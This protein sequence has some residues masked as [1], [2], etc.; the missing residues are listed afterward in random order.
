MS[1]S[2][3]RKNFGKIW[4]SHVAS[5]V[6]LL[7]AGRRAAGDMD[8]LLV[9]SVI[10]DRNMSEQRTEGQRTHEELFEKW[11]GR[12]EPEN[13]NAQSIADY[14]GIPR[15][16]VRRKINDLIARDWIVKD[17]GKL[18]VTK[19]CSDDLAP[20]TEIGISY[21]ANMLDLF[22]KLQTKG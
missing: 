9:L 3:I 10:G 12:P 15:E 6:R 2:L 19:K 8:L 7:I 20:L 16:T 21:L 14:T 5:F 13:T 11:I 17:E 1:A 22:S 18:I 4:P